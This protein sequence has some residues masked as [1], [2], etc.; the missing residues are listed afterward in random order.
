MTDLL[1]VGAGPAGLSAALT[2]AR[3]GARVTV[4]D[5][6]P[7][8]G[9]SIYA[10]L[11]TTRARRPEIYRRLGPS[12]AEG[13]AL[14]DAFLAAGVDY[15][16]GHVL[17]HVEPDGTAATSGPDGARM[18][19]A[20]SVILATGA[21]ERPMPLPGWTLPGVM[22][23]GAAQILLKTSGD[24]PDGPIV[25][26]GTGPLS[27]LYAHQ[28]A[29]CGGRIAA[30]VEPRGASPPV[31]PVRHLRGAWAG[32]R[33]VL[34]GLGYLAARVL[35]RIPVH[36]RATGIAILGQ[37]R[38]EAVRFATGA[39][40]EIPAR[41]VLLHDGVV[42]NVNPAAAAGLPVARSD[43]QAS[44]AP[45]AAPLA[46]PSAGDRILV[47]GDAGGILGAAAAR[48]SGEVAAR[49]ALGQAI[50][51]RLRRAL[52][53]ERAFRRFIDAVYP[54]LGNGALADPQT[55][56]CRCEMVT[57]QRIRDAVAHTGTDPNRLKSAL[58]CGM[59]PCQ[60]RMCALSVEALIA[61]ATGT[62]AAEIG[63]H[64]IRSPIAPVTLGDLADLDVPHGQDH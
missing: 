62:P 37:D 52:D 3:I 24:L 21:Q 20:G 23:V 5:S 55:P 29:A 15:R 7:E 36:R 32:R 17:W 6:R 38:V 25:I 43:A 10:S 63:F 11:A 54:P 18:F 61:E 44:W 59:G 13:A 30:F 56:V 12:Y 2:A 22:G 45:S 27:L 35:R 40:T 46:P 9:G 42:P 53:R 28:V 31:S 48:V 41:A 47:A 8:P 33:Y 16:P 1:V 50:P 4:V 34:K 39:E 64:R 58:R 49:R 51:A 19:Q 57:A 60:G 26:V 14:V